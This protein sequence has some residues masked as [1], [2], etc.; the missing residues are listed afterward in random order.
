MAPLSPLP[1]RAYALRLCSLAG[2]AIML[3]LP[4]ALHAA[5]SPWKWS[6]ITS[7]VKVSS[8]NRMVW[9]VARM[10]EDVVSTDG[11]AFTNGGS[12]WVL[13][14]KNVYSDLTASLKKYGLTR[15]DDIVSN[16]KEVIFL[17][18]VTNNNPNYRAVAWDGKTFADVASHLRSCL[19]EGTGLAFLGGINLW[20]MEGSDGLIQNA[21]FGSR[22]DCDA[23]WMS[24]AVAWKDTATDARG[25]VCGGK[26]NAT[27][28][29]PAS[30]A[31]GVRKVS[32]ADGHDVFLQA[33]QPFGLPSIVATKDLCTDTRKRKM[34]FLASYLLPVDIT[35]DVGSFEEIGFLA[36]N[37]TAFLVAGN[38]V[39]GSGV[40]KVLYID[41]RGNWSEKPKV[42]DFTEQALNLPVR[43]WN[44]AIA[45]WNGKSWM[46]L[47][48]QD[49]V[50]FDGKMFTYL[51]K[52]RDRF[53][54][55]AGSDDGSFILG[56]TEWNASDSDQSRR[57]RAKY[58]RVQEAGFAPAG[59]PQGVGG[60]SMINA[61]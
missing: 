61:R 31:Y 22:K 40:T 46:I 14:S 12:A 20:L 48:G 32:P 9:S 29:Y 3:A 41:S 18:D 26:L 21:E 39:A 2:T 53:F 1:R 47:F 34:T 11:M 44:R 15:V 56:G 58:V 16:G 36:A 6:D 27:F 50:R 25:E 51:G 38:D 10:G 54:T 19:A 30:L 45:G 23:A 33:V 42:T 7:S 60:T 55:I 17:Q 8:A 57:L 5:A 49:L 52:T 43:D 13:D 37:E 35:N 24:K 4:T 28:P 59:P